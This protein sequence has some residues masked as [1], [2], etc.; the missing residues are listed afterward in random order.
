MKCVVLDSGAI[1]KIDISVLP[2][3]FFTTQSVLS[4]IKN[5]RTVSRIDFAISAGRLSIQNPNNNSIEKIQEV[6]T[7]T[8]DIAVLSHVDIDVLALAYELKG[9]NEDVELWSN[10]FAVQN[11]ASILNISWRSPEYRIKSVLIWEFKCPGCG[12]RFKKLTH[13]GLCDVC[14]TPLRRHRKKRVMR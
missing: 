7:K 6:A 12:K 3:S 13:D 11:V 5:R 9:S 4:E 8:G 10:D 2:F 14:G 1:F